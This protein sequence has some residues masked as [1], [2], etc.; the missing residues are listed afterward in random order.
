MAK[1]KLDGRTILV[2]EDEPFIALDLAQTFEAAGAIVTMV[3]TLPQALAAV[4]SDGL[5]AAILDHALGQ[6]DS[7]QLCERLDERRIPYMLYSG[8]DQVDGA[9]GEAPLL[10]KPA[11]PK[12][13][14][15]AVERLLENKSC[16]SCSQHR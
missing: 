15:S 11:P 7:S 3:R 2:V 4:E 9:C 14:I 12:T 13:L 5:S 16:V 1:Q 6:D 10:R 8:L